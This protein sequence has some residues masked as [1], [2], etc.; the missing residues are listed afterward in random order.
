M[1][2]P[3]NAYFTEILGSYLGS[4]IQHQR[5]IPNDTYSNLLSRF[6]LDDLF[7]STDSQL[8]G[9]FTG[10]CVVGSY[11]Y[12][13]HSNLRIGAVG[14]SANTRLFWDSGLNTKGE[15]FLNSYTSSIGFGL[16]VSLQ[17]KTAYYVPTTEWG[18]RF[19][20]AGSGAAWGYASAFEYVGENTVKIGSTTT[21]QYSVGDVVEIQ[22]YNVNAEGTF[23]Q[24]ADLITISRPSIEMVGAALYASWA[25][26]PAYSRGTYYADSFQLDSYLYTGVNSPTLAPS[27]YYQIPSLQSWVYVDGNGLITN[28]GGIGQWAD[29]DPAQYQ[30]FTPIPFVGSAPPSGNKSWEFYCAN[31]NLLQ[32]FTAYLDN[33]T[34]KY[35]ASNNNNGYDWLTASYYY[36]SNTQFMYIENGDKISDGYCD[37]GVVIEN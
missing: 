21:N 6:Y 22:P 37:G 12:N 23:F 13:M 9:G 35:V 8:N 36:V 7:N 15:A 1:A 34:G 17:I 11:N 25:T 2:A 33:N 10:M 14:A 27:G 30:R 4:E 3:A 18:F 31:P 5:A 29:G 32:P 16:V 26:E 19:R 20:L 28:G 24:T